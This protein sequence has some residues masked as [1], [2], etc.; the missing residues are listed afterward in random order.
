MT[1][2]CNCGA[3][4]SKRN[5]TGMCG[6]CRVSK[7]HREHKERVAEIKKE[8]VLRNPEKRRK[9]WEKYN[10][11]KKDRK[12]ISNIAWY[13]KAYFDGKR[14]VLLQEHPYCERCKC[15]DRPLHIHHKDGKG[16]TSKVKNN[17]WSNLVVLCN[18]CH[19]TV[20]NRKEKEF[21]VGA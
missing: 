15:T 5:I 3:E 18:S 8:Y 9:A 11:E 14:L 19:K 16:T 6:P 7:W 17:S 13:N 4:L 2:T 1:K 10:R 20:H 12:R 21:Y